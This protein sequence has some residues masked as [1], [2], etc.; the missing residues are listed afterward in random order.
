MTEAAQI[1]SLYADTM[2]SVFD[3]VDSEFERQLDAQRAYTTEQNNILRE[4]L[5]NENLSAEE[6][7]KIQGKIAE[8]DEK[9]RRKSDEIKKKQ[10]KANKAFWYSRGNSEHLLGCDS[11]IK[12]PT[13]V[14]Y[15]NPCKG[16]C[17]NY[18][19]S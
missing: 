1:V 11:S 6:R 3:F 13:L 4:Q 10:F 9:A 14:G 12:D 17:Y 8:N 7:K 2:S 15:E 19:W 5:N 18:V 16:S